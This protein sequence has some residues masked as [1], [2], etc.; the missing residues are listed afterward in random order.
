MKS[1]VLKAALPAAVFLVGLAGFSVPAHAS[2]SPRSCD[3][4][5][6]VCVASMEH[7]AAAT[8]M[9][10]DTSYC[11]AQYA[12]C[13]LHYQEEPPPQLGRPSGGS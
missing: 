2:L 8:G 12:T 9:P 6:K 4:E 1:Y 13:V 11:D 10:V 5:Y 3:S 7:G